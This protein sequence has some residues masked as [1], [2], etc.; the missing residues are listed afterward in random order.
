MPTDG[1]SIGTVGQKR[2]KARFQEMDVFGTTE[3]GECS[4]SLLDFLNSNVLLTA[5]F[6]PRYIME[7]FQSGES[8][9][10]TIAV[11]MKR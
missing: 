1:P 9:I 4:N 10:K 6:A 2:K 5:T 11:S 3:V 7:T 8:M